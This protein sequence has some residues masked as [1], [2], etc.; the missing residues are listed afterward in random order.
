MLVWLYTAILDEIDGAAA[1]ALCE[2]ILSSE[3]RARRDRLVFERNRREYLFAHGLLRLALSRCAPAI[4]PEA[5]RFSLGPHGRPALAGPHGAPPLHFNLSHTDGLV[6]CVIS[7][8][9]LIGID[10]EATDRRTATLEIAEGFFAQPEVA[11]LRALPP[12]AARDRFFRTWTLKE[13]YIK[14]RGLGL[15]LPLDQFWFAIEPD[16]PIGISFG[17]QLA[18]EPNRWR[19]VERQPTP[20]HRMAIALG[21]DR[22]RDWTIETHPCHSLSPPTRGV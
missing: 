1:R 11:A 6:A 21:A 15:A 5:W 10:V 3:E 19:F 13:S 12:E 7:S 20:R 14:A 2:S 8:A 17:P 18:D 22:S 4:A 16:A 9:P